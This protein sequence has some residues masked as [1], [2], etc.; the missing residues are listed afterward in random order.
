[1]YYASWRRWRARLSDIPKANKIEMA[2]LE[3]K[4]KIIL[5]NI[6]ALVKEYVFKSSAEEECGRPAGQKPE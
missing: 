4:K 5:G 3:H 1:M 2:D 6:I